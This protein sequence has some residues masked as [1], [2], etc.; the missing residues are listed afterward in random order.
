MSSRQDST[1]VSV[2]DSLLPGRSNVVANSTFR[3]SS[4]ESMGNNREGEKD[5]TRGEGSEKTGILP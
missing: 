5:G 1:S 3:S 2:P 4:L